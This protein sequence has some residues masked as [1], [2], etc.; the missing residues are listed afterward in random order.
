MDRFQPESHLLAQA[1]RFPA[2]DDPDI[3]SQ[4]VASDFLSSF[5]SALTAQDFHGYSR[6][7]FSHL[8][9]SDV[10]VPADFFSSVETNIS[11]TER[12]STITGCFLL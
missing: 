8:G 2:E 3:E 1:K 11:K 4:H 10:T 7:D 9:Y 6:K 5:S 12:K